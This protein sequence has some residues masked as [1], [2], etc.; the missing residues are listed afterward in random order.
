VSQITREGG[1]AVAIQADVSKAMDV[2][3][4]F[5]DTEKA[6]GSPNVLVNN[7]GVSKF[8]PLEALQNKNSMA[9]LR[10]MSWAKSS[11]SNKF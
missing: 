1:R 2:E 11:L 9:S 4:L 3:R 8:E 7:A 6:F 10:L 5:E